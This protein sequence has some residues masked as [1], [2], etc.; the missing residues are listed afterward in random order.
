MARVGNCFPRA[1]TDGLKWGVGV[2]LGP[3]HFLSGTSCPTTTGSCLRAKRGDSDHPRA[4]CTDQGLETG[5]LLGTRGI[6][7]SVCGVVWGVETQVERRA[8]GGYYRQ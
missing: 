6:W 2:C 4:R 8:Q 1:D 7:G 3:H 5:I